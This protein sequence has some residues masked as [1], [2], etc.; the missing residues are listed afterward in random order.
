MS[1]AEDDTDAR[2]SVLEEIAAF[3]VVG[4]SVSIVGPARSGKT[5]LVEKLM[6][7]A[8]RARLGLDSRH[9]LVMLSCE[10]LAADSP[11]E[12]FGRLAEGIAA[13]VA[14]AGLQPEPALAV[15][16]AQLGRA[17]FE[18]AVRQLGRR[19]LR[20]VLILDDFERLAENGRLDLTFF[21]V[22]RSIATR[23]QVVYVTA[24]RQPLIELTYAGRADNVVSS[25][26][27]NI[28]APIRLGS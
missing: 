25:P 22:L 4:Q 10:A 21:N 7:G 8:G 6:C 13:A 15:A 3:I 27:F 18:A 17:S 19:G 16:T 12:T 9:V 14:S 24:S 5:A 26:F 28:F 23:Y 2:M 1:G 20:V 11:P